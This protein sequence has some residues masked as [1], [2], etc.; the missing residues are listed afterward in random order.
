VIRLPKDRFG[1][2]SGNITT[3]EGVVPVPA[4]LPPLPPAFQVS[5]EDTHPAGRSMID[6]LVDDHYQIS[7]LCDLLRGT[8]G[9]GVAA[10]PVADVLIAMLPRHLS[11]EEQYLYPTVRAVL[12]DGAYLADQELA[13]DVAMLRTL[14]RLQSTSPD[15]PSYAGIVD[16]VM[17]QVRRH[18]LRAS[19]EVFPRLRERC[20]GNELVRLGNRVEIAHEAAPTRPHPATPVTPPANKV[21]D[22]WVGVVDK[23]RDALTGRTTWP[24]D[25]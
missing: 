14:K 2:R 23:V 15:D 10:T 11:A 25:L 7:A 17:R 18:A 5:D 13:E 1:Y 22:P 8:V 4:P 3:T 6:I 21:V 12:P 9:E 19:Q 16:T 20:S 24:E